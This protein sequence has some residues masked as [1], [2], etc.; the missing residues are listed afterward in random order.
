MRI[1]F[2]TLCLKSLHQPSDIT[3]PISSPS[4][5]STLESNLSRGLTCD[6]NNLYYTSAAP[7]RPK[8]GR[9]DIADHLNWR[10]CSRLGQLGGMV[11]LP[12]PAT[13]A[14]FT[15][16]CCNFSTGLP[17]KFFRGET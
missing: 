5:W 10:K 3:C 14:T 8:G 6:K 17:N 16:L 9:E 2:D 4:R 15:D 13:E 1:M 11:P 12:F 7:L